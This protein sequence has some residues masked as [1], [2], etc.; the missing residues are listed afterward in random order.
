MTAVTAASPVHPIRETE[1]AKQ[2]AQS[3]NVRLH[4]IASQEMDDPAFLKNSPN[5]CYICKRHLLQDMLDLA[6]KLGMQAVA[7]GVNTDDYSDFRPGLK[8]A[9]ELGVIAP[10]ADAGLNK[11]E[12]RILS[13][14]MGLATWNKAPMACLATRIP[15]HSPITKEKL[16]M[17]EQ[18]E[19]FLLDL[20]FDLCRVRHHGEIARIEVH[21]DQFPCLLSH[22]KP[23]TERFRIIGFRHI[24]LDLAGY[25]T[26]STNDRS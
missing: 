5:R 15:C 17:I 21:P 13:K 23:V 7:H 2:L 9:K 8:A 26:G 3:L 24:T 18:A 4:V 22:G 14:D 11:S 12:I 25:V 10:L 1:A 16:D 20:G 6:G 19:N